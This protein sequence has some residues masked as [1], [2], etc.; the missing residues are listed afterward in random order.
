MKWQKGRLNSGYEKLLLFQS[1]RLRMDAWILRYHEGSLLPFHTDPVTGVRHFRLNIVLKKAKKGGRLI[2][3]GEPLFHTK[4]NRIVF[5]R[6]DLSHHAVTKIYEG[7]R[8]VLS[9]GW[10]RS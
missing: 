10:T 8:Y 5:F 9:I 2:T 3:V 4:N 6:P 7:T 1:K